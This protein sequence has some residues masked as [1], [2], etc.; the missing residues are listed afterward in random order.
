MPQLFLARDQQS[1]IDS[2]FST[3]TLASH[4]VPV[5]F[6][7]T[8]ENCLFVMYVNVISVQIYGLGTGLKSQIKKF[9]YNI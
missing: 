6:K 7:Y 4:W 9:K 1:K 2:P 3:A 8:D 5:I